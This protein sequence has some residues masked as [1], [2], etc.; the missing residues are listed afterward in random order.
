MIP[1]GSV[2]TVN[3]ADSRVLVDTGHHYQSQNIE[4]I[5]A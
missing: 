3:G 5:V 2:R 4:Q 1:L